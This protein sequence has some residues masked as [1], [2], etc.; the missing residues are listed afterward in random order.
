MGVAHNVQNP[1]MEERDVMSMSGYYSDGVQIDADPLLSN[2]C[3]YLLHKIGVFRDYLLYTDDLM[4]V[5]KVVH[6]HLVYR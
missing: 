4:A 6:D 5:H 3:G 2:H 1:M